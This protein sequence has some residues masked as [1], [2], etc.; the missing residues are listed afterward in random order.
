VGP[1]VG[2][3]TAPDAFFAGWGA[4]G[5]GLGVSVF[6]PVCLGGLSAFGGFGLF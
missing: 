4:A 5:L 6:C 1:V 2:I 3:E